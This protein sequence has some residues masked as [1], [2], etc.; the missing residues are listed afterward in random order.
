[1][2][3]KLEKKFKE[4]LDTVEEEEANKAHAND[5]EMLHLTNSIKDATD[6]VTK[7]TE[8]KAQR[9][10]DLAEAKGS[11]EDTKVDLA[12][13]EKFLSETTSVFSQKKEA[14]K[15]SQKTR[16]EEIVALE[17]A[18]EIISSPKVSGGSFVQQP[19]G[20]SLLQT[21]RS[22]HRMQVREKVKQLL[23]TKATALNSKILSLALVQLGFDPFAKVLDMIK[24]LIA[25][26]EEEAQAE[27]GHKAWCDGELKENKLARDKLE[28]EVAQ[29]HASLEKI[30]GE[31]ETLGKDIE[32][33]S[34]AQ[35]ALAK[36]MKEGTALRETEKAENVVTIKDAKGA[37][38]AVKQALQVLRDF[39]DKQA[40]FLQEGQTAA[41]RSRAATGGAAGVLGMLEVILSDFARLEAET[42]ADEMQAANEYDDFIADSKADTEAKHTEQFDKELLKDKKE[43]ELKGTTEDT[44]ETQA[45]LDAA[46]KYFAELKP[47]CME[48]K[49]SYEEKVAKRKEELAALEEAYTLLS[50]Q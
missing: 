3:E 27:A 5:L 12:T 34:A 23:Q 6:D 37:Q 40:G 44:T 22:S 47:Q 4:Q 2:L 17:K 24:G 36:A 11:L 39:Y 18:I 35:A 31:I 33:L 1:M 43:H 16:G 14:F 28:T 20:V 50:Q 13:S 25:R 9:S 30:S 48:V 19:Q 49:V 29:L 21:G 7:R 38:E 46:L 8:H 42:S 45:E 15:S 32:D 26:L 41:T 10:Q